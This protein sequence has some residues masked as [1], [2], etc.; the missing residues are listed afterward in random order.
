MYSHT[1]APAAGGSKRSQKDRRRERERKRMKLGEARQTSGPLTAPQLPE[2]PP[3]PPISRQSLRGQTHFHS[4]LYL[5]SAA[6][7]ELAFS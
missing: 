6:E 1:P 2:G 5:C 7:C 3:Y 4:N